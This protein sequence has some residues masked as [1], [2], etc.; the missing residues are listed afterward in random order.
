MEASWLNAGDLGD[1]LVLA[2][3]GSV[4][5]HAESGRMRYQTVILP[6]CLT[7]EPTT[8]QLLATFSGGGRVAYGGCRDRTEAR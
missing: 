4:E 6:Y 7:L 2:D 3:F 1:E 8:A 5:V